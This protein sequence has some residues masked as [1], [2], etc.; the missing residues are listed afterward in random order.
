MLK[1]ELR[2]PKIYLA[3]LK[4]ISQ[5]QR[6]LG[7]IANQLGLDKNVLNKYLSVLLNLK[8]VERQLPI[9]ENTP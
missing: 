9:T 8:I 2:E 5:D 6:K 4:A 1:E 7:K 3:I